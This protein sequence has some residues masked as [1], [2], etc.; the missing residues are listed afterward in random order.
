MYEDMMDHIY[1][2]SIK[3]ES[4][5]HPVMMSEPAVCLLC[6]GDGGGVRITNLHPVMMSEPAVCI[7]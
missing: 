4:N 5:L 1:N 3:S 6:Q 2:K 7:M